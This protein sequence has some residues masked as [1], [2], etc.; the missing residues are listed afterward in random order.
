M[1]TQ[2]RISPVINDDTIV[3][4]AT[5]PGRGALAIVRLSGPRA[6][7]I[8]GAVVRPWPLAARAAHLCTAIDAAGTLLDRPV[9]TTYDAPRSFTGEPVVE[10]ATHGGSIVPAAVM[11]ACVAAGARPAAPGEFTRRAVL[12]GRIDLPQAEAIGDLVD[13]RSMA[14]GRAAIHQMDGG[15][16]RRVSTLRD[17]LIALDALLAYDIDFPEEDDGP[18]PPE[19]V[20]AAAQHAGE[21]LE[22]LVAAGAAGELSRDGVVVVIAGAPNVGKSSLFNA[23]IGRARALVT[24]LPGT[25]RDAI[26]A[27]IEPPGSPLPL[28]LADTAGLRDAQ[29]PVEQLGVAMSHRY[30]DGAHVALACAD[31]TDALAAAVQLVRARTAA[32]VVAVRTKSDL[33]PAHEHPTAP[34]PAGDVPAVAVS[35]ETGAGLAELVAAIIAAVGTQLPP[36]A[37]DH[38]LIL[39]E[40]HRAA[41]DMA[42]A[43]LA[44]F[45]EAWSARTVPALVAAVHV[46]S[47][48]AA[49]DEIIGAVSIDDVLDRVFRDFCVGK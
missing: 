9:V 21:L 12:N 5:P 46:R 37:L 30:L 17:A 3:A 24:A 38:P 41:L 10:L 14:M 28:R 8:A 48:I 13:A 18:I 15:L 20:A 33:M 26:E 45:R 16:S 7:A 36:P 6:H 27:V 49:L 42:A 19:H 25:T 35:A 31:S 11:A 44:A 32:P 43:E 47:A 34:L 22:S 40:R 2:K 29:D 39:R 4:V 1:S 23:L